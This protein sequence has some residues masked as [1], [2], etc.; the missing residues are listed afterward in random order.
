MLLW[1][2][3]YLSVVILPQYEFM[4]CDSTEYPNVSMLIMRVYCVCQ[5][6]IN[7]IKCVCITHIYLSMLI[8]LLGVCLCHVELGFVSGDS[9]IAFLKDR[10]ICSMHRIVIYVITRLAFFEF[11]LASISSLIHTVLLSRRVI[12]ASSVPREP[13]VSS[14]SLP[15]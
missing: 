2:S 11:V 13:S 3:L 14:V 8:L 6:K 12:S 5:G 7:L 15:S 4:N 1:M 10:H 9:D